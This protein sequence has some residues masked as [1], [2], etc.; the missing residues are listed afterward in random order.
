MTHPTNAF[1]TLPVDLTDGE[2]NERRDQLARAEDDIRTIGAKKKTLDAALNDRIA[3]R[4]KS[5]PLLTKEILSRKADR[6]VEVTIYYDE[7]SLHVIYVR[8]D[9]DSVVRVREMR[10]SEKQLHI[11]ETPKKL[12]VKISRLA[13]DYIKRRESMGL[14]DEDEP[15]VDD[16]ID[17]IIAS[18]TDGAD[19]P[20]VDE[21]APLPLYTTR[22]CP[23]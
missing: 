6:Q 20:D 18:E 22:R 17:A 15:S 5:I 19:E 11:G 16:E 7:I 8:D 10:T 23:T 12:P 4:Q 1:M 3:R 21:D 14:S 2:L 13:E 9:T